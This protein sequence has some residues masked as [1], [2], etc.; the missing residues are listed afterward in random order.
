MSWTEDRSRT[1]TQTSSCRRHRISD[2]LYKIRLTDSERTDIALV[3]KSKGKGGWHGLESAPDRRRELDTSDRLREA[4]R[5][6]RKRV[7][8]TNQGCRD[9]W[10]VVRHWKDDNDVD[11]DGGDDGLG[12]MP[13][14]SSSGTSR[15]LVY[16]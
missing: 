16:F 10:E 1:T 4:E 9:P 14:R 13:T 6:R 7:T 8:A 5:L 15:S 3:G 2:Q 11:N 12:A